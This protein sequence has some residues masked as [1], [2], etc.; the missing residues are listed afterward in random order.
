MF[1]ASA[2]GSLSIKIDISHKQ[3]Y[4]QSRYRAKKDYKS[5]MYIQTKTP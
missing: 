1:V 4:D 5:K 3:D 2:R